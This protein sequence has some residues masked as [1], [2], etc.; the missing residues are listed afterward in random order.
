VPKTKRTPGS[1]AL[2]RP[3]A[4]ATAG[5]EATIR[6][7]DLIGQPDFKPVGRDIVQFDSRKRVTL[8]N[9]EATGDGYR[10]YVNEDGQILLDPIVTIPA[11]EAWLHKNPAAM[12]KVRAGLADLA[13]GRIVAGPDLHDD[14][15]DET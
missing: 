6:I 14:V 9:V 10:A 12:A 5:A 13:A 11:R 2:Q 4:Q 15:D 3:V 1:K 8:G 7:A